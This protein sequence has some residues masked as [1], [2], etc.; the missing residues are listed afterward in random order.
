MKN[1]LLV[2]ILVSVSNSFASVTLEQ[3][4]RSTLTENV[5]VREQRELTH[6]AE[7]GVNQVIGG[8]FPQI[9][10]NAQHIM[11]PT[12]GPQFLDFSP[13]HQTTLS[14]SVSQPLFR[15]LREFAG[16]RKARYLRDGQGA[17]E[18]WNRLVL[19]QEVATSFL[20]VLTFEQDLRN[21][22]AQS[23]VYA[24]RSQ[25]MQARRKR[26]ESSQSEALST[27]SAEASLL[28][29][30]RLVEGQLEG[31]REYFSF[32]TGLPADTK[33]VVPEGVVPQNLPSLEE[34]LK[35][36][37]E[38]HDVR[39]ATEAFNAA[40]E[41]V[42]IAWGAHLPT[43]DATGNYYLMRPGF[44]ND[45]KWDIGIRLVVPIFEGGSTSSGVR[46]ALS[47]KAVAELRLERAKRSAVQEIRSAHSKLRARVDHLEKLRRSVALSTENVKVL[48]KEF[49]RG[50][51]RNLDV[52]LA[53]AESRMANRGLDQASFA[54]LLEYYQLEIAS[55]QIPAPMQGALK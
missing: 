23:K 11:Q 52:Q 24:D 54:A 18:E 9:S 35:H 25:D 14:F 44:F 37:G 48:Q 12:P 1:I 22:R 8:I 30:L 29:E 38:R 50:L 4:F 13:P 53:L 40:S 21:L 55:A 43:L 47:E 28:A 20:Q 27:E 49:K 33:L 10:F 45:L 26:G 19:F 17:S 51:A 34:C 46:M 41:S 5:R 6:Q 32:L 16:L 42:S 2:L 39:A 36:A 7:E 31:S 3:A 15:G